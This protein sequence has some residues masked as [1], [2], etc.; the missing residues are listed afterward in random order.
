M[1]NWSTNSQPFVR[2]FKW[3]V[4]HINL[5]THAPMWI[6]LTWIMFYL[7][8][9]FFFFFCSQLFCVLSACCYSS[10]V[11]F[12]A[13]ICIFLSANVVLSFVFDTKLN[14][15]MTDDEWKKKRTHAAGSERRKQVNRRLLKCHI[16]KIVAINRN[17]P[18][19]EYTINHWHI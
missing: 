2:K 3:N 14:I 1:A 11:L 7:M 5:H 8:F 6:W 16:N 10:P 4:F 15:R 19:N 12:H 13:L 18:S 9:F 17:Y